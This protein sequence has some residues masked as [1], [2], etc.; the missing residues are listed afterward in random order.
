MYPNGGY[1]PGGGGGYGGIGG[2]YPGGTNM[3]G[4]NICEFDLRL[5]LDH[6]TMSYKSVIRRSSGS[7]WTLIK[8]WFKT[9]SK[10]LFFDFSSGG[11]YGG[12]FGNGFGNSFGYGGY[13]GYGGKV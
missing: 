13:G 12:G 9:L 11:G 3:L 1:F 2:G 5:P 6:M 4:K 7:C 8:C 10:N